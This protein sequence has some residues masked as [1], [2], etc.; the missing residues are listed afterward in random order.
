MRARAGWAELDQEQRDLLT[1]LGI[2]EDQE[3]AAARAAAAAKP[4]V[5]RADRFQQHLSALAAFVERERH[6]KI[7]RTHKTAE[8]LSPG[9]WLN[10]Q[11]ARLD[12]LSEEQRG[13]LEVLGVGW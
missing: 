3:L 5:S 13:Q 10:N 12:K 6:A 9:A 1:A 8:G 11:K 7:P 2:E 4:K